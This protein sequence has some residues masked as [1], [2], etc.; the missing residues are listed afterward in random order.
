MLNFGIDGCFKNHSVCH[1]ELDAITASLVG[2]FFIS[3]YF[4]PLGIP[5]ENDMIIPQK[6]HRHPKHE[7]VIGIAGPIA[8]GKTTIGL[9]LEKC[10]YQYVRYSLIIGQELSNDG[11]AANRES[12]RHAGASLYNNNMQYDLNR[13]ISN[14]IEHCPNVA[15]DGMRH[16]ED[17]TYW[18]E[19]GFLNFILIYVDAPYELR[20]M[21]FSM[22]SDE[23]SEYEKAV[24]HP[25]EADVDLLKEKADYLVKNDGTLDDLYASIRDILSKN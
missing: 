11:S 21:R 10:G 16:M 3:N 17:Y 25:A 22:R 14:A 8:S 18:K 12:L 24:A 5:E 4:E 20:K 1:D 13:K 9:Y 15:I 7:M 6:K 2:Q 19:S 23:F